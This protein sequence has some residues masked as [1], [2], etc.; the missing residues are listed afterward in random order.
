MNACQCKNKIRMIVIMPMILSDDE[1]PWSVTYELMRETKEINKKR[2]AENSDDVQDKSIQE[3]GSSISIP[4]DSDDIEIVKA[5][6]RGEDVPLKRVFE[7]AQADH[8]KEE[9]YELIRHPA[10]SLR[11]TQ[12]NCKAEFSCGRA[13]AETIDQTAK[14]MDPCK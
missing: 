11:Y 6:D 1:S 7:D 8:V 2:V 9:E 13:I 10:D 14:G 5:V 3:Q 4:A 12:A